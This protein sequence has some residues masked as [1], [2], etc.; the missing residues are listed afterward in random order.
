MTK[1]PA[2]QKDYSKKELIEII[3]RID[4]AQNQMQNH[5]EN[6]ERKDTYSYWPGNTAGSDK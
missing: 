1:S 4:A 6:A 2:H 5:T 3:N